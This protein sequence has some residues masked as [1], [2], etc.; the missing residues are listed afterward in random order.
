MLN[1]LYKISVSLFC[2]GWLL[3]VVVIPCGVALFTYKEFMQDV[4]ACDSAMNASWH[5]H[6]QDSGGLAK[7]ELVQMLDCH[8][9]DKRRKIMML[10][11]I[12]ETFLSYLGLRALELHQ[13]PAKEFV[14][15]H[16]FRER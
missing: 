3:K 15:Q 16:R 8:E 14:E 11:G 5:I 2:L 13:R 6:Q 9:Y 10:S 12:P 4:I 1:N 7:S